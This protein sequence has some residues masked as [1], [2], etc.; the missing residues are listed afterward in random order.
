MQNLI[1]PYGGELPMLM[2]DAY[3]A[4]ALKREAMA[5][6]SIV[7]IGNSYVILN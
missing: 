2:C 7:S 5:F 6:P 1:A 3:R 4:E